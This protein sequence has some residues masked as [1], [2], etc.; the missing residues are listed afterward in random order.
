MLY[1]TGDINLTDGYF[2]T[3]FGVGS[4]IASGAD[5][6]SALPRRNE[7]V[8]IGNFEGVV[9]HR[10]KHKGI[11]AR[12]FIVSP[13]TIA[14][15]RHFRYYNVANNHA[16]QHG[17]G[18]FREMI[19]HLHSFGATCFGTADRR[20]V[21]FT[22]E[23]KTF[24]MTGFSQRKENFGE[25]PLYWYNPEYKAIEEEVGRFKDADFRIAYIHWGNEFIDRPYNDQIRLA[26]MLVDAGYDLIVGMHPHLLQGYECYKGKRIYYSIG[27]FVFN[28]HWEPLRYGA[29]V[30]VEP[31]EDVIV[32]D[33]RYVRIGKDYFPQLIDE[34]QVPQPYRFSALNPLIAQELSNEEYYALLARRAQAYRRDNRLAIVKNLPKFRLSAA[35]EIFRDYFERHL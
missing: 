15:L 11:H 6:F 8:W 18:A 35:C 3:G 21:V 16:M 31:Q 33:H 32:T 17:A 25:R 22:H 10:S 9:A 30:T 20:S 27:N 24:I 14:P 23:G 12:Q 7:D 13:E 26:H 28:M 5:P 2:D 1:L 34:A 29:V 4:S 19:G